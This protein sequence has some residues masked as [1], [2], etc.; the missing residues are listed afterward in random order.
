MTFWLAREWQ[1]VTAREICS[2]LDL[3]NDELLPRKLTCGQWTPFVMRALVPV[4][5]RRCALGAGTPV[6]GHKHRQERDQ[7][8]IEWL[9]DFSCW[10]EGSTPEE[11]FLGLPIAVEC[12]WLNWS[13]VCDDFDKLVQSRAGLR[14]MIFQRES[15]DRTTEN[16]R[17][18]LFARA[19]RFK[20][21]LDDDAWLLACWEAGSFQYRSNLF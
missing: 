4:A 2:A 8:R 10:L 20:P 16:W 21:S 12:E 11:S 18:L 14:V 9:Y 1:D 13:E 3:V 17:D 19:R 6:C 15:G 5:Q 7:C